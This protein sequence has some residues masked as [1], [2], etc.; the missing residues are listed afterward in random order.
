MFREQDL[1]QLFHA[2]CHDSWRINGPDLL[3]WEGNDPTKTSLTL[4][5][6]KR[7]GVHASVR[8]TVLYF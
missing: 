8:Y 1:S 6:K 7:S 2:L 5:Q 3:F 4:S